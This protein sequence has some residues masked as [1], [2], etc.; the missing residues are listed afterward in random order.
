A[1]TVPTHCDNEDGLLGVV[2]DRNF[3]SN[4]WLY[5][6]HAGAD[7]ATAPMN[8]DTG[9]PHLLTRYTYDSTKAAGSQLTNPKEILRFQR[10]I[11][12][13]AYH[14]GGGLDM[15]AD[16]VLVIGTGDDTSPHSGECNNNNYGPL[17]WSDRGCDAQKSSGNTN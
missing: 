6:F 12:A 9:K 7:Y 14:A 15:G 16:G 11:D 8:A 1:G 13:R 5:V 3:A 2:L 4:G 17:L 10:M